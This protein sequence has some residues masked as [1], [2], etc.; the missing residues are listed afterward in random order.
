MLICTIQ[1]SYDHCE[2][3]FEL[4]LIQSQYNCVKTGRICATPME[5]LQ[6]NMFNS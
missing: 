5:N 6:R 4:S 3:I 2:K 1:G